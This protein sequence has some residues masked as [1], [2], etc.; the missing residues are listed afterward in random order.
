MSA[1]RK[2]CIVTGTRADYGL[3]QSVMA[4]VAAHPA[5]SLQIVATGMHLSPE[6][7]LTVRQIEADGFKVD[8]K[9]EMLLSSDTPVGIAKSMGLATIGFADALYRL[10]PDLIVVLGDRFEILAAAQAALV[11]RIPIAHIHGGET[12]EGAFDEGIRHSLTKMAQWHFVSAEPYRKRVVQMGEAPDRV[13]IS[14]A[15]GLDHLTRTALLDRGAL[16]AS[17]DMPLGEP[18]FLV[19]Y[20]PATLGDADP[21]AAQAELLAALDGF[22]TASV[23]YTLPN[24][25][26]AGRGLARQATAWCEANAG[27]AKA[28]QSLGQQRYLSAMALADVTIGNSSS[29]LIETP[30][31]KRATVNIGMRQEGRLKANSVID[32]AD[33]RE[34]IARAIG[35]AL[36]PEFRGTLPSTVSLYGQGEAGKSIAAKLASVTLSDSKRFFDIKHGY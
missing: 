25:D 32:A 14:G 3:L 23:I 17:L 18:L 16:A 21:A 28:F 33:D 26:P 15:P 6:F 20:H 4:E 9:V 24:A 31:L 35:E 29:G 10:R 22:P 11:A 19:T 7:G 34:A 12:T 8:E 36:S 30:A 2:I 5:L 13:F 1:L 27:R